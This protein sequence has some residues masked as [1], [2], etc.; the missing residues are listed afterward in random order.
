MRLAFSV[1]R[2]AKIVLVE[3]E[4]WPNLVAEAHA[5]KIP[6]ALVNARLSPR[7]EKRFRRFQRFVAP[8][9]RLLD[10]VCVPEAEDVARWRALGVE[11]NRI[12]NVGSIKYDPENVTIDATAPEKVLRA[13]KIE[14]RNPVILGGS[15]H[16]GEEEI[17]AR[18][19]LELR[20]GFP[21]LLLIVAPRHVERAR[22]IQRNLQQLGLTVAL[23]SEAVMGVQSP[24]CLLLDSTGEL[25]NWYPAAT[26]VFIGKS[27]IARGGQNPAEA[28]V[29]GRPVVFGPHMENFAAFAKSLIE[30]R[31][32]I[33]ISS[34]DELQRTIGDLLR[35]AVWRDEL[36]ENGRRLLQTHCGATARTAALVAGLR[37]AG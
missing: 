1:I 12:R 16:R 6:I 9:F 5:R 24:D 19:F 28:I 13:L 35:D 26:V 36:A 17:L 10:L 21:S 8:T 27:L 33:Q 14:N 22:E 34:A 25:R 20:A 29:A 7:S 30:Q 4:V 37:L 32:A 31:A 18:M 15:T 11:Q 2:P 3:A 23:R